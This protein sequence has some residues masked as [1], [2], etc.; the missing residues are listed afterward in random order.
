MFWVQNAPNL[1]QDGKQTVCDFID[2]YITCSIPSEEEDLKLHNAVL[3]VQQHSKNHF[4]SCRKGGK[5]CRFNFSRTPSSKTFISSPTE[6]TSKAE[7]D[8]ADDKIKLQ[9]SEARTVLQNFWKKIQADDF[10]V[11]KTTTDIFKDL[12]ITHAF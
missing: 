8:V 1:V 6:E 2:K 10:D 11:D 3:K 7:V 9:R 4:K 12:K 5:E